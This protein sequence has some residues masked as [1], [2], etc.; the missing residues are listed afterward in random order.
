M[1]ESHQPPALSLAKNIAARLVRD[2]LL[3]AE[4]ADRFINALAA[5]Q[6]KQSDWRLALEA[7]PKRREKPQKK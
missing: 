2:G 7:D 1:G 4:R 6:L 3:K 5:G